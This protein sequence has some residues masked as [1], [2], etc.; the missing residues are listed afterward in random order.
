[1]TIVDQA[2]VGL[3]INYTCRPNDGQVCRVRENRGGANTYVFLQ[4]K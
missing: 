1:M 4:L 3:S 2:P